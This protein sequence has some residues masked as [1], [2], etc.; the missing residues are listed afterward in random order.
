MRLKDFVNSI[1]HKT[2][3]IILKQVSVKDLKEHRDKTISFNV[4]A[5]RRLEGARLEGVGV[6][7]GNLM[8]LLSKDGE[9]FG[10]DWCDGFGVTLCEYIPPEPLIYGGNVVSTDIDEY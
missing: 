4:G 6:Y 9:V 8:L 1:D 10:L 3:E 2:P 5:W 7:E